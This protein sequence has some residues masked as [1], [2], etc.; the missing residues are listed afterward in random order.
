MIKTIRILSLLLLPAFAFASSKPK[1]KVTEKYNVAIYKSKAF[2][3]NS[4]QL[5]GIP[6]I[7]GEAVFQVDNPGEQIIFTKQGVNYLYQVPVPKKKTPLRNLFGKEKEE[8]ETGKEEMAPQA[9]NIVSMQWKDANP[10]VKVIAED[11]INEI[12]FVRN[13]NSDVSYKCRQ[14]KKITYKDLYPGID[15][16]Y[17]FHPQNGLK[18]T[19][20]V[21]PGADAAN[22]AMVYSN[23]QP[24]QDGIGNI[25]INT[26]KGIIIDHKPVTTCN[27]KNISS[28][29]LFS[30]KTVKF[31]L[32]DYDHNSDLII[33]PWTI[34]PGFTTLNRAYDIV[35]NNTTGDL[36]VF[37][38]YPPYEVKKLDNQGNIQWTYVTNPL[39][40]GPQSNYYGDIAI[41][42]SGDVYL[43]AGCCSQT[44]VK[45][46]GANS[47][48]I[49]Q[50]PGYSEPWRL[51]WD[52]ANN[53]LI[54]AGYVDPAGDNLCAINPSNGTM[55]SGGTIIGPVN[56]A[57]IRAVIVA[58]NGD[59]HCIHVS[60]YP[61]TQA[62]TNR[63]TGNTS[64]YANFYNVQSG[65]MLGEMGAYYASCDNTLYCQSGDCFHGINALALTP[66]FIYTFD[67]DS[68]YKRDIA[69]GNQLG[70]VVIP[71]GQGQYNSGIVIDSCG[72]IFVGGQ[73]AV[74]QYDSNLNLLSSQN[75]SGAV[76]DLVVGVAG[77]IIACGNGFVQSLIFPCG[78]FQVFAQS[79]N[80]LCNGQCNGTATANLF[81]G[82]PPYTF[83]WTNG[84]TT[85]TAT[86]L[87][88]GIYNVTVTDSAGNTS[89][90]TV[91]ITQ[92]SA[93][94]LGGSST[95]TPCG[96][97]LGTGTVNPTGGTG[98]Y[99]YSWNTT[100]MQ[101]TAT[102]SGLAT[103]SYTCF[104]TDANGCT[105]QQVVN[106]P[107]GPPPTV[108]V[109]SGNENCFGQCFA[110]AS[111]TGSSG[112]APY[113]YS[114]SNGATGANI[115]GLCPGT[116][117]C[118]I[119][120][121]YGCTATSTTTTVSQPP[122]FNVQT[123]QVRCTQEQPNGAVIVNVS[124][125]TPGYT[126][127]WNTL[128]VQTNDT[129]SGLLPGTY[130][131]VIVDN[132]NCPDTASVTIDD[133]PRDSIHIPNVFTPNGDPWNENF[134]I[135]NVGY[136]SFACDIYNRWG[137]KIYGWDNPA[138]YWDGKEDGKPCSDGVYYYIFHAVKYDGTKLDGQ[139]FVQ[140]LSGK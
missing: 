56:Q 139:G 79:T 58:S 53:R 88:A 80:I 104:V 100:P 122:A 102:A 115:T 25:Y 91:T 78:N 96:A 28:E 131:V 75:T 10:N 5:T 26:V 72:N 112:T 24:K 86:G 23:A 13:Y 106:V 97:S 116:Y 50:Q 41:D 105:A 99:T 12:Y 129:A 57:E 70:M 65:Y 94:S 36:F 127:A 120:D 138:G 92:P 61:T 108:T 19:I 93:L 109:T 135:Y 20:I 73:N 6:G 35:R 42:P 29:Y 130:L 74:Y 46:S 38:G 140:L 64:A 44:I 82:T 7:S 45:I 9:F 48:L 16:E 125:G 126:Y 14:F 22:I 107:V 85:Q 59:I 47:N 1:S 124:G 8:T 95:Q 34:S 71:N 113:T 3:E 60:Q 132:N 37:G 90:A 83:A 123:N 137:N 30:G 31:R 77:E 98:P 4:G 87:C 117:S 55:I 11:P 114:W 103:G 133:C 49:W 119:T 63:L 62:S 84:D 51:A 39:Y 136:T 33:D 134:V 2:I 21:H 121:N 67:G 40:A 81:G 101:N 52:P 17:V 66:N 76:F 43:S 15:V 68:L 32:D 69:T 18:Y 89:T 111:A 54:A 27:G 128:P 110:Q 118:V